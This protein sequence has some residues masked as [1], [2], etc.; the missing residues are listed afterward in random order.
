MV[1]FVQDFVS[2]SPMFLRGLSLT[3]QL[4]AWS[5]FFAIVLGLVVAFMR[6]SRLRVLRAIAGG[7]LAIVRG[8][9]LVAQLFVIYYGL[10]TIIDL[11]AYWSAIA[12]L[13]FH[14]AAYVAEIFRGGIQSV[15]AGQTEAARSMGMSHWRCMRVVVLPQAL[16]SS[17]P[18]LGNQFIIAVK[19]SS[20]AAFITIPELFLQG[21]RL[22][23]ATFQPLQ[24]YTFVAIYYFIIIMILT[25]LVKVLER[26]SQ[27]YAVV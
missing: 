18:A 23:A 25:Q 4:S 27:T 6:L 10:V 3:L 11:G 19:D 24:S 13:S 20:I 5:I 2:A 14:S 15:G 21:Q 8:T 9:P 7:Y 26:R 12:G 17:I 1:E 16:R 22:A